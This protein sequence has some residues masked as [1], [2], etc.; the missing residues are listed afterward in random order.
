MGKG[1]E[2][3]SM[4]LDKAVQIASIQ[5]LEGL[6]IGSLAMELGMS[7]SG[8]FAKFDS[9]ENLQIEVLRVGS[10]LFRRN[11][12]YPALKT[13]PGL[14]RL[15]IAFQMWLAWANTDSLPG[16]CL[17]LSSSSEFDDRPGIVRDYLK[18]IQLSWQK[19]LKQFVQ[20]A[21][22]CLE[23]DANTNVDKMV[24]EIWSL[25]LGFHFYNRLLEDKNADKKTKQSFNELIKRHK[26]DQSI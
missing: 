23:L 21:K 2:T 3:K 24:Q 14:A 9:K 16:G 12:V 6:T 26:F 19:T 20:D 13:K 8:L 17:F 7:K 5:G 1:E 4:I 22:D 25:I 11:V 15:K 10:E 18:K